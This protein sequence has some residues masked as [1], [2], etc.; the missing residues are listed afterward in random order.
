V[1]DGFQIRYEEHP[2]SAFPRRFGVVG[3]MPQITIDDQ[4]L[5]GINQLLRLARRGGLER[6]AQDD[7]EPW[8]R[9]K[10]R[11]GRGYDVAVLDSLGRELVS[12]RA[13]TRAGADRIAESLTLTDNVASSQPT[14]GPT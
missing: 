8:V 6:I 11:L 2:I 4:H 9:I 1:L 3:S 12:H 5:G 14:G 10:R 7:R 13:P